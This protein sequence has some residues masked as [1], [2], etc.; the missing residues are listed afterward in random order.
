M[1]VDRVELRIKSKADVVMSWMNP[2]AASESW[3]ATMRTN[4]YR[5]RDAHLGFVD[6]LTIRAVSQDD[7]QGRRDVTPLATTRRSWHQ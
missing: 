5:S 4:A 7:V 1:S 2:E 6:V 3:R